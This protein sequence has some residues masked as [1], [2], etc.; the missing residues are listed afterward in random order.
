MKLETVTLD[1]LGLFTYVN[2][3]RICPPHGYLREVKWN[4]DAAKIGSFNSSTLTMNSIGGATWVFKKYPVA[5][6]E[7]ERERDGER[8]RE[9]EREKEYRRV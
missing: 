8:E 4:Q 2:C 1:D 3:P 9:K 6:T 5:G 7:R